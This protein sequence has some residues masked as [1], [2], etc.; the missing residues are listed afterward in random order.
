MGTNTKTDEPTEVKK[1]YESLFEKQ[2]EA[3]APSQS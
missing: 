2:A 3:P 1:S